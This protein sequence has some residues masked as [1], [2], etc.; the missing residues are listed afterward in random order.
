[1]CLAD[2]LRPCP[3]SDRL[4]DWVH[5][6]DPAV[7]RERID[8][9]ARGVDHA[10]IALLGL[11]QGGVH[12]LALSMGHLERQ[13]ALDDEPAGRAERARAFFARSYPHERPEQRAM[14][15]RRH[16]V[17]ADAVAEGLATQIAG[18]LKSALAPDPA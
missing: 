15:D 7:G 18:P 2:P 10:P 4:E 5:R 13:E 9:V 6:H 14:L 17:H 16:V 8:D 3:A 12:L 11:A 1:M